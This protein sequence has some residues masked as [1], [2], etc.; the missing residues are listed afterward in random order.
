MEIHNSF[1]NQVT[2]VAIETLTWFPFLFRGVLFAYCAVGANDENT[3]KA[4]AHAM[5]RLGK[6]APLMESH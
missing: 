5:A 2:H 6:V 4:S 1:Y 3:P